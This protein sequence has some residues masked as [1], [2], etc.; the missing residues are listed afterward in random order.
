[1]LLVSLGFTLSTTQLFI[2]PVGHHF[3]WGYSFQTPLCGGLALAFRH[4]GPLPR[5]LNPGPVGPNVRVKATVIA[6]ASELE[7]GSNTKNNFDRT[8]PP[9]SSHRTNPSVALHTLKYSLVPSH[10]SISSIAR[11]SYSSR[12]YTN[13][14]VRTGSCTSAPNIARR[15]HL[16][17][18]ARPLWFP[19]GG[20]P[21]FSPG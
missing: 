7:R 1:M 12:A 16:L 14:I 4:Q 13:H 19:L 9:A 3:R 2:A 15:T 11:T 6:K 18:I 21:T 8:T 20:F 5:Q 17:L 10:E